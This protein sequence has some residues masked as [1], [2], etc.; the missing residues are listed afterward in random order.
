[1]K[2][3]YLIEDSA[4]NFGSEYKNNFI[5]RL[6]FFFSFNLIKNLNLFYGGDIRKG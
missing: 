5:V 1:M 4:I 3:C 2:S 6:V